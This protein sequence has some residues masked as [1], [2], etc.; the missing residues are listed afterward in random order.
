MEL[1]KWLQ[2]QLRVVRE[3]INN[4]NK[5]QTF[6]SPEQFTIG[7]KNPPKSPQNKGGKPKKLSRT[8]SKKSGKTLLGRAMKKLNKKY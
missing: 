6:K 3:I 4:M 7:S 5:Q 1:K 8:R 2:C